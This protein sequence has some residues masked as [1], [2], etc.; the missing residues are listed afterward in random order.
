MSRKMNWL[1]TLILLSSV[2]ASHGGSSQAAAQPTNYVLVWSD[3]FSAPNGTL[4]D[5]SKWIMETGGSGWGNHELESYTNRAR[6]AHLQNGNLVITA[7]KETYKGADGITRE[8][9]SARLKT[10]GLFEQK[11]GRFEARIKIPRGQGMWPAFWMLGN[12]I[13]TVDWPDC[14]EIDIMENVGKEPDKVHGTI[15]GP[16]YWGGNGLGGSYTLPSGKFAHGFHIFAVEWEPSAIRFYVDGHLYETRTPADLPAGKAWVFDHP[17]FIL[18]NVAVGGDWPGNPDGTTAF[19][20]RMLVDYV[21]VYA[22][23]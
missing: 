13:G 21:K 15:H 4:P 16:G 23:K 6:N 11:Y 10:L 18:L 19:P 8:Y 2:T 22:R 5:S 3:E 20:Q 9:T 14:G 7:H 12:N 1:F 17:F